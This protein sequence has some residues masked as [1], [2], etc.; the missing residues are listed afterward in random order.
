MSV[1]GTQGKKGTLRR[2]EAILLKLTVSDQ[3]FPL[4]FTITRFF[5]R[6]PAYTRRLNEPA[7]GYTLSYNHCNLCGKNNA[8][9]RN[10]TR[11]LCECVSIVMK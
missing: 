2:T 7:A 6:F 1:P 8:L 9:F 4:E 5:A 10:E 11:I 3:N